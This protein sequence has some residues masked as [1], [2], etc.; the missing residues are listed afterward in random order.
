MH[1]IRAIR[2]NPGQ[3][4]AAMARRGLSGVSSEVLAI[5][6]ARR[7][8]ITAAETAQADRNAASKE[9]G[10]AKA[11]GDEAEFERL[12]ALV[13]EKK[14]EIARLEEEAKVED[15]RLRD[16]LMGLP[17]LPYDDVPDGT[18]EDDNLELHT[19]GEIPSF[20][21]TP[22]EHFEIKGVQPGMDFETAAKL[23]GSRFV[24][25]SGAVARVHRA[26]SQMMLD[27]H[28]SENGLSEVI[29]RFWCATRRCMAPTSCPSSPRTAIRPGKANG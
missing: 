7:A 19:W 10:A 6:E 21:F 27:I 24:L 12:R 23:S 9:V 13:A 8:R 29:P 14:D 25:M 11:K 17:N 3:F 26:L 22:V 4:D 28:T 2:E 18:D 1:D 20:D 5:D 16:L 15:A